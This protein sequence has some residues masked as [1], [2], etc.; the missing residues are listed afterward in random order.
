MYAIN[1]CEHIP[2]Y[3]YILNIKVVFEFALEEL[4]IKPHGPQKQSGRDIRGPS[5]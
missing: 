1:A 2:R 3:G 5:Q 4:G